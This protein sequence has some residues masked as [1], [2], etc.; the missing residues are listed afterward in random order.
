MLGF[1]RR[2]QPLVDIDD[3]ID[4]TRAASEK[5][6]ALNLVPWWEKKQTDTHATIAYLE[7]KQTRIAEELQV[8]I[9]KEQEGALSDTDDHNE[10]QHDDDDEEES[11]FYNPFNLPFGWDGN[12]IFYWL[13]KL[14]GLGVEYKCKLCGNHCYW[15]RR[16]FDRHFQKWRH[17]F[18]MRC[19]KIPNTKH[20]YDITRIQDA[21]QLRAICIASVNPV[22]L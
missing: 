2:I 3:V 16:A 22:F 11:P 4:E 14:H 7:M 21:M 5:Q 13:Y 17:A 19:R 10:A 1:Y 12:S 8:E 20:F 18:G 6:W 9:E 15:G